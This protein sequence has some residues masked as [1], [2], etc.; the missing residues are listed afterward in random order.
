MNIKRR[1]ASAEKAL[2]EGGDGLTVI[3]VRGGFTPD[4]SNDHERLATWN[5]TAP[6]TKARKPSARDAN[7]PR[8]RWASPF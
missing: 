3:F 4:A 6:T 1:I 5:G 8:A 2:N 7:G